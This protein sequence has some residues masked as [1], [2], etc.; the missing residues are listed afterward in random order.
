MTDGKAILKLP[1]RT[2]SIV[3]CDFD[4]EEKAFYEAL[5]QKTSLTFNKVLY[6]MLSCVPKSTLLTI[7]VR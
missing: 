3:Q 5:E 6:F 1:G 4:A 7:Q 2:V